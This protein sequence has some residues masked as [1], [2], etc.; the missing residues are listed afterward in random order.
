M[1]TGGY[2]PPPSDPQNPGQYPGSN[3]HYGGP[4]PGY[5]QPNDY[6]QQFPR[7]GQPGSA[8]DGAQYG[9]QY[10]APQQGAPQYGAPQQGTPHYGAPQYGAPQYGAPQGDPYGAGPQ[11]GSGAPGFPPAPGPGFGPSRPGDLL[12]RLGARI[13]DGLIVGIP[14]GIL[15]AIVTFGSSSGFMALLMSVLSGAVAFG[16]WTYLESSKGATFGKQLLGLSVVA[17]GGGLPTLE[18]AGK[19]NAFVALQA[20]TGIPILGW[21]VSIALLAA[22]IGIAVTIEQDGNKQGFHDKFAGGTQV[23]KS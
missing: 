21:L 14:M 1:T 13:I 7:Q 23:V 5:G 2:P 18:Q 9:N 12:P 8:P 19:R 15:T 20:L 17:P 16:Y 3:P 6:T 11:F 4:Q 22:Y 10:G